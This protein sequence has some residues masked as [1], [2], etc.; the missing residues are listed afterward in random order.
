MCS[1]AFPLTLGFASL[2]FIKRNARLRLDSAFA[3]GSASSS[4]LAA[5][6]Y[7]GL[8]TEHPGQGK[9]PPVFCS[10]PSTFKI[11]YE[12]LDYIHPH[13]RESISVKPLLP[14]DQALGLLVAVSSARCRASTSVLSTSYSARD[15]APFG[16]ISHLGAGFTLRCLQRL[17][18]PGLATLLWDWFPAGAPA[19]RPSRSS[20]TRDRP[21]QISCARAG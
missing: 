5:L 21:P 6:S 4:S 12:K 11:P 17:S 3:S 1:T 15:L 19:A 8:Y 2:A 14:L 10:F 20:R 16:W 18:L 7:R 9:P 13:I